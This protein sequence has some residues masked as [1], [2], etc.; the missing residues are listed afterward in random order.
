MFQITRTELKNVRSHACSMWCKAITKILGR[1]PDEVIWVDLGTLRK[2]YLYSLNVFQNQYNT[3][4][5]FYCFCCYICDY[6]RDCKSK[7]GERE[8]GKLSKCKSH[9][10]SYEYSMYEILNSI[11]R[12]KK[13]QKSHRA[14]TKFH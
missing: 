7:L 3:H 6:M 11:M 4:I 2:M 9:P 10:A 1:Y 13:I 8:Y 12:N 5:S 14:L